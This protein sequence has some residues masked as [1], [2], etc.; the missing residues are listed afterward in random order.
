MMT[1]FNIGRKQKEREIAQRIKEKED[2]AEKRR[3]MKE[4]EVAH[5]IAE[6]KKSMTYQQYIEEGGWE[7]VRDKKKTVN[8]ISKAYIITHTPRTF[9]SLDK[10]FHHQIKYSVRSLATFLY[11]QIGLE[12]FHHKKE[13]EGAIVHILEKDSKKLLKE[14]YYNDGQDYEGTM[15]AGVMKALDLAE[16]ILAQRSNEGHLDKVKAYLKSE[17]VKI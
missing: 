2:A 17:G 16:E 5:R 11:Q 13:G 9:Q 4:A 15:R 14:V 6:T 12:V 10:F 7:G 3:I 1:M 8:T